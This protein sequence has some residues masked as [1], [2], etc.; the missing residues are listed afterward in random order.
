MGTTVGCVQMLST[1]VWAEH[2]LPAT[3]LTALPWEERW[4]GDGGSAGH[5]VRLRYWR[6]ERSQGGQCA[7][8]ADCLGGA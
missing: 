8:R 7:R 5:E 4:G 3:L 6:G 2:P 1:A